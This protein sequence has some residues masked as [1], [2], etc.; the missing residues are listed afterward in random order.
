MFQD[1]QKRAYSGQAC[2]VRVL[3]L[4]LLQ[5]WR[6]AK[7]SAS[8]SR[9]R[10]PCISELSLTQGCASRSQICKIARKA[11]L[12]SHTVY[13]YTLCVVSFVTMVRVPFSSRSR[14]AGVPA[15]FR[16]T[17]TTAP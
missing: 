3:G 14:T 12:C 16:V 4:T 1:L 17:R 6:T 5:S 8:L 13:E 7:L 2:R 11:C 9:T 10:R 15:L